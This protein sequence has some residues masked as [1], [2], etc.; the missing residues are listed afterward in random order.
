ME[1]Q[2]LFIRVNEIKDEWLERIPCKRLIAYKHEADEEVSRD[3][4]H[5]VVMETDVTTQS[6]KNWLV[7]ALGHKVP[8]T[9]WSFKNCNNEDKCVTYCTKGKLEPYYTK[10]YDKEYIDER[11][12][13]W[14]APHTPKV[15]DGKFVRQISEKATKSRRQMLEEIIAELPE[16]CSN[17][18]RILEAIRKVLM[19]NDQVLGLYKM[20][21][22]Y[23]SYVMYKDKATFIE[24]LMNRISKH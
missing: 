7:E 11:K 13:A 3:H 21:D 16:G 10:N 14:A 17:V 19:R 22:Y 15:V 12:G 18:E 4:Y 24:K 8:K 9:D 1:T 5:L 2:N 20:E 23:W 6:L